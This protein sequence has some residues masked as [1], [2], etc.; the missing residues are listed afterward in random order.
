MKMRKGSEGEEKGRE[1]EEGSTETGEEGR[2]GIRPLIWNA[3][4]AL[5][6]FFLACYVLCCS[7]VSQLSY[8]SVCVTVVPIADHFQ[9]AWCM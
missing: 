8:K 7:Y 6:F 2:G 3:G 1:E 4:S 5:S 9:A